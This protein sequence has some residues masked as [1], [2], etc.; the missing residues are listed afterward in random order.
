MEGTTDG[1]TKE[2]TNKRTNKGC[3]LATE[4]TIN[5]QQWQNRCPSMQQERKRHPYRRCYGG[6][7]P[8]EPTPARS[9]HPTPKP[10]CPFVHL[11]VLSISWHELIKKLPLNYDCHR[12]V[13]KFELSFLTK[14]PVQNTMQVTLSCRVIRSQL[15]PN[16]P[17]WRV[18]GFR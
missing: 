14:G 11:S 5:N 6:G 2:R 18:C 10:I 8:L 13:C 4:T 1:W 16:L 3:L 15:G 12:S 9:T 17:L 7:A